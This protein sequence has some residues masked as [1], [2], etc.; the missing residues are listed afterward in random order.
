[1]KIYAKNPKLDIFW[2]NDNKYSKID[3]CVE[4]ED[5]N[6][7]IKCLQYN[8]LDIKEGKCIGNEEIITEV[9]FILGARKQ[10][11]KEMLVKNVKNV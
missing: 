9:N 1:L 5:E 2:I 4:S 3:K 8:F 10:I 6:T 11:K 7:C